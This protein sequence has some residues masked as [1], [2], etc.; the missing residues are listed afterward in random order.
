MLNLTILGT[1]QLF[2][3]TLETKFRHLLVQGATQYQEDVTGIPESDAWPFTVAIA[4]C[5]NKKTPKYVICGGTLIHPN[6]VL[7]AAHCL[8][9]DNTSPMYD[10]KSMCIIHAQDNSNITQA[11]IDPSNFTIIT[12]KENIISQNYSQYYADNGEFHITGDIGLMFL[13]QPINQPARNGSWI[14][15]RTSNPGFALLP[16]PNQKWDSKNFNFFA[17]AVGWGLTEN[18]TEDQSSSNPEPQ[19]LDKERIALQVPMDPETCRQTPIF[20]GTSQQP[21]DTYCA[22]WFGGFDALFSEKNSSIPQL[23]CRGDSGGGLIIPGSVVE[24]F[25]F[26]GDV[27]TGVV[28]S[29]PPCPLTITEEE[30]GMVYPAQF[31]I[32]ADYVDWIQSEMKKRGYAPLKVATSPLNKAWKDQ[33]CLPGNCYDENVMEGVLQNNINDNPVPEDPL[34]STA[35]ASAA[36]GGRGGP[37]MLAVIAV[38]IGLVA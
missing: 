17:V 29:G 30:S 25:N 38:V 11:L 1:C 35:A 31:T 3:P 20:S 16:N 2:A 34:H 33:T 32:V 9:K 15:Q 36:E 4:I 26:Q 5:D 37:L 27:V 12:P 7:T 13:E 22:A 28:S 19:R 21:N 10:A 14:V 18:A 8:K 24:N 6:V 23:V